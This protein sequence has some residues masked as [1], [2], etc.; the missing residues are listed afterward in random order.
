MSNVFF[1]TVI[2]WILIFSVPDSCLS[3]TFDTP[4]QDFSSHTPIILSPTEF[5]VVHPKPEHWE[6]LLNDVYENRGIA[7]ITRF[8]K[9]YILN[10]FCGGIHQMFIQ[11]NPHIDLEPF[12]GKFVQA[13]YTY[14][15]INKYVQ[16]VKKPCHPIT[17]RKIFIQGIEESMVN[18]SRRAD[19]KKECNP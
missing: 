10:I 8:A 2:G 6:S 4:R 19:F 1:T 12:I 18:K 11:Q 7:Q 5:V 3:A 9:E 16:C 17:E 14:G 15:D 13:R